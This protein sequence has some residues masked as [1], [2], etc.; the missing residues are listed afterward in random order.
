[1]EAP[2]TLS[3][4]GRRA[5]ILRAARDGATLSEVCRRVRPDDLTTRDASLHRLK[6]TAAI[7][8]LKDDGLLAK[9]PWGWT[10]TAAGVAE[11]ARLDRG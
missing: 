3:P 7:R 11:I 4:R 5:R 1:M 8:K 9:S 6:T 10:P 2:P